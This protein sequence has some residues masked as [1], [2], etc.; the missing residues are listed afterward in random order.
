MASAR[1]SEAM[2]VPPGES[3]RS[4]IALI[5]SSSAKHCNSA[6]ILYKFAF[7]TIPLYISTLAIRMEGLLEIFEGFVDF[8]GCEV[9][10]FGIGFRNG[11][12]SI[13]CEVVVS[14]SAFW[15]RLW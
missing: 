12:V 14:S 4:M 8:T 2:K 13:V 15:K 9:L 7:A 1:V 10:I 11:F 3:T 5:D 6:T